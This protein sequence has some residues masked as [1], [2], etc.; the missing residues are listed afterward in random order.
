MLSSLSLPC[1]SSCWALSCGSCTRPRS[2]TAQR[3]RGV[4][5]QTVTF[6]RTCEEQSGVENVSLQVADLLE[7]LY[8]VGHKDKSDAC[9]ATSHL[10]HFSN[11][12]T[13]SKTKH[14]CSQEYVS[15][16]KGNGQNKS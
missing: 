8:T 16:D 5:L 7:A 13:C 1:S 6:M 3:N 10:L 15:K 4:L 14:V 9:G 2:Q 12:C 11:R